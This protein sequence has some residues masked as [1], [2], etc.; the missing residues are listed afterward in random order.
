M[1]FQVCGKLELRVTIPAE[2][3]GKVQFVTV[4]LATLFHIPAP[5]LP[6]KVQFTTTGA[7]RSDA[8]PPPVPSSARFA[9]KSQQAAS[10][11][12]PLKTPTPPPEWAR[13]FVKTQP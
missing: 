11:C 13:L 5:A 1:E 6:T 9:L 2:C 8:I 7:L 3:A 10:G 4:G 12:A